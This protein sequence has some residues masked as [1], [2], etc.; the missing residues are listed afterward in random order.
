MTRTWNPKWRIEVA[1]LDAQHEELFDRFDAFVEAASDRNRTVAATEALFFLSRYV[2]QHFAD[3]ERA[4]E[5]SGY[6]GLGLHREMHHAFVKELV[7]LSAR[8]AA[9]GTTP[10]FLLALANLFE[11]WLSLHISREDQ[12]FGAHL[13]E[14]AAGGASP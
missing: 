5:E 8:H 10:S 4:M 11:A 2:E 13:R 12:R 9:Q 3:E 6:P 7:G 1:P 14:Q